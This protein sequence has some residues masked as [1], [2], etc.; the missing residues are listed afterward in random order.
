[1]LTVSGGTSSMFDLV[2]SDYKTFMAELFVTEIPQKR[3]PRCACCRL[4]VRGYNT[5]THPSPLCVSCSINI[6]GVEVWPCH[7]L[8]DIVTHLSLTEDEA[9]SQAEYTKLNHECTVAAVKKSS[10]VS[11]T[12]LLLVKC[13]YLNKLIAQQ[14]QLFRCIVIKKRFYFCIISNFSW[15][16]QADQMTDTHTHTVLRALSVCLYPAFLIAAQQDVRSG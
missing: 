6:G 14:T 4:C 9:L 13:T 3:G 1:M 5:S 12:D 7:V 11:K 2:S 8:T 16:H 10:V 15:D